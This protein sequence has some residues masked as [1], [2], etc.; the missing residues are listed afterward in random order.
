MR[1]RLS[2]AS[3]NDLHNINYRSTEFDRR[4]GEGIR[5]HVREVVVVL[6]VQP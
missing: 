5:Q 3:S 6:R 4:E 2:R 1:T